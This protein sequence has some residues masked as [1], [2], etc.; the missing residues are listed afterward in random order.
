M[1][2]CYCCVHLLN[3]RDVDLTH[4]FIIIVR[5]EARSSFLKFYIV[6]VPPCAT[7]SETA[8]GDCMTALS[9]AR[10]KVHI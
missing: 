5:S 7:S 2:N 8:D 9:A 4:F 10:M 3:V 1:L 6:S